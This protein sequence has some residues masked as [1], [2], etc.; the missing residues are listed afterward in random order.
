MQVI[1]EIDLGFAKLQ[2]FDPEMVRIE[3]MGDLV[4]GVKEAR[5]INDT[6]GLLSE[7]KETLVLMLADEL[8]Q[9]DSEAREF[10]ASREGTRY[11]IA[12]AI[13]VKNLAQRLLADFYLKFNKP[14]KPSKIFSTEKEAVLWLFSLKQG[15]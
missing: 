15:I 10:S 6:I 8:T 5:E 3:M 2:L 7:N 14:K 11:T 12:D 9:F 13:V 4:I 1:R